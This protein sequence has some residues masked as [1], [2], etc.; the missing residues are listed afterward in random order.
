MKAISDVF[1]FMGQEGS[2]KQNIKNLKRYS[3]DALEAMAKYAGI[4]EEHITIY[5]QLTRGEKNEFHERY[6]NIKY[7]LEPGDIILVTGT[8][9]SSKALVNI[10]K[11]VYKKAQASH[12]VIVQSDFIC[13]D[14][15]PKVGVSLRLISDVLSD[16]ESNWRVIRLKS[17]SNSSYEEIRKACAYYIDQPY[18][19]LP[20]K[21]P[22]KNYSYCSE[23]ARKVYVDTNIKNHQI[24]IN[25]LI[26]PCDFDKIADNSENWEDITDSIREYITFC[27]EFEDIL[28][29]IFNLVKKGLELNRKRYDERKEWMKKISKLRKEGAI[30]EEIAQKM[31][32]EIASTEQSLN[33]KFW[34]K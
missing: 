7:Q 18:K 13:I 17:L 28:G 29:N 27:Q 31:K 20:K 33:H 8:S 21:K 12:V 14:A 4:K 3:D 34:D 10:Q 32:T 15:M 30:S 23:L 26:K 24:P 25:N 22:A 5:K 1:K 6:G 9:R 19:I 16:V 2:E 11:R